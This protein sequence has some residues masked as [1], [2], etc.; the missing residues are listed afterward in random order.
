MIKFDGL[1]K[2]GN[3]AYFIRLKDKPNFY[4]HFEGDNPKNQSEVVYRV[5]EGSKGACVWHKKQAEEFIKYTGKN[6]LEFV[7][8][9]SVLGND[10]SFN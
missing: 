4:I 5:N 1:N 8:V 7:S 2:I 3:D 9:K 10:S 6:N